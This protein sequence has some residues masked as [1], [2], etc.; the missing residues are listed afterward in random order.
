MVGSP[1]VRLALSIPAAMVRLLATF[2]FTK[3]LISIITQWKFNHYPA[4]Q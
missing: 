4:A 3:L 2:L 1:E